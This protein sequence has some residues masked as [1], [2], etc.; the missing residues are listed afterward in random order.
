MRNLKTTIAMAVLGATALLAARPALADDPDPRLYRKCTV[1]GWTV[2]TTGVAPCDGDPGNT[3]IT[4]TVTGTGVPDHLGVFLRAEAGI[5]L[6]TSPSST[7]TNPTTCSGDS[8]FGLGS[9]L[10]CHERLIHFSNR[11]A[12][13]TT[14]TLKVAGK[15]NPIITSVVV[16]K[17][18]SQCA[19]PIE[20]IGLEVPPPPAS[21]V[22]NC[23]NF[24][25][26]Q[27]VRKTEKFNFEGC[28]MQFDY[29]ADGSVPAGG[30]TV[31]PDPTVSPAPA[32]TG[33]TGPIS[34]ILVQSSAVTGTNGL[35]TFGDGW[36]SSGS[37]SCSTRMVGGTYYTV[38]R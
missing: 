35:G 9:P 12:L 3:C 11:T 15:R 2:Q 27:S 18:Y 20:G 5:P 24:S 7:T 4:Y 33:S 32:C 30:F 37:N 13:A 8:V 16:R 36:L 6:S 34:D 1:C 31:Y 28:I 14:F 22:N 26:K 23:G 21:C 19:Y 17:G 29:D 25:P 38:C 10:L